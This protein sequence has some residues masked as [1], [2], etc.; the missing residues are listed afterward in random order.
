MNITS[1]DFS[2]GGAIPSDYTCDAA[3]L[4]PNIRI[5]GVPV[6]TKS[7]AIVLHDP[8]APSGTFVHWI[9]WNIDPA[10]TEITSAD[11]LTGAVQGL[12]GAGKRGYFAPCPP[13]GTHHYIFTLYAL[14]D[15]L[16]ISASSDSTD[17]ETA[18][19]ENILAQASLTGL[20]ARM[21]SG[22]SSS[23]ASAEPDTAPGSTVTSNDDGTTG[24]M[25]SNHD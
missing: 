14:S 24:D 7:L 20:Y 12:N 11:P 8:D 25:A 19:Q 6:E 9:V 23:A 15:K 13:T 1:A 3:G 2:E 5:S 4:R 21:G 22:A 16:T 17:L 10:A 18:M